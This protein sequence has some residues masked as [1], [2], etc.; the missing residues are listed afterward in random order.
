MQGGR[1]RPCKPPTVCT[2]G[3]ILN[4]DERFF[5]GLSVAMGPGGSIID[6]IK[7]PHKIYFE[8]LFVICTGFIGLAYPLSAS[9][10]LISPQ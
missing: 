5:N 3:E 9:G 8:A 4:L 2:N 7:G 6:L 1:E 10:G